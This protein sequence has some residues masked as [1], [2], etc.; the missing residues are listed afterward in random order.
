M[1]KITIVTISFNQA[2]YLEEAIRSVV[3]Q[4]YSDIEYIVVDPGSTDGS[5]D[6]IERY[7]DRI[8]RVI[9]EPDNGPADGLNKGFAAAH[10]DI[11]GF[12]NSDDVLESGAIERVARYFETTPKADVVSGHSW[13]ID[14]KSKRIRR[15][16]SDRYSLWMAAHGASILSQASTFFRAG[17][18]RR[19][20]GFNSENRVAWDGELFADMALAGANFARVNEVWSRF[21]VHEDG[22][23]GSGKLHQAH[24]EYSRSIFKKINGRER[25]QIDLAAAVF[26]KYARKVANPLDTKERLL[27]GPIY[28]SAG[29]VV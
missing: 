10:G 9:Y 6:I 25:A 20:G 2:K 28:R 18:Y 21:R 15:F 19:A 14:A 11:F 17:I 26:A 23:T 5:R 12:L 7:Q 1:S 16:Y 4:D 8:A 29:G 27:Y 3:E 13:I 22:I 24:E